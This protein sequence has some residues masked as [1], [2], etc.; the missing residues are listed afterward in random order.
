MTVDQKLS[1]L[2]CNHECLGG[3]G[4]RTNLREEPVVT[5]MF[6]KVRRE[7]SKGAPRQPTH[8]L[9]PAAPRCRGRCARRLKGHAC[10]PARHPSE[11]TSILPG[12]H[13]HVPPPRPRLRESW[14]TALKCHT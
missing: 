12:S 1:S 8:R 13:A 4:P 5:S 6:A 7:G 9:L 10:L 2:S 3:Q 11:S 14:A